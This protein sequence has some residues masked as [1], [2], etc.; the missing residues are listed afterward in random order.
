MI[1][2]VI[3]YSKYFR[4]IAFAIILLYPGYVSATDYTW[5]G[6]TSAWTTSTNWSP[7]SPAGG[8]T[9]SD[10]V[11]IA[12]VVSPKVAPV[13]SSSV[14]VGGLIMNSGRLTINKNIILTVTT[15]LTVT[16]AATK[17]LGSGSL[18]VGSSSTYAA[19]V[20]FG[21]ESAGTTVDPTLI[22]YSNVVAMTKVVFKTVSLTATDL[23]INGCTFGGT[24]TLTKSGDPSGVINGTVQ[25]STI[26]SITNQGN[27]PL[28][29][30]NADG[31]NLVFN[32]ATTFINTGSGSILFGNT[33]NDVFSFRS[34]AVFTK[35]STGPIEVARFGNTDFY[36]T[37][38]VNLPSGETSTLGNVGGGW[39]NF[40]GTVSQVIKGTASGL[41]IN[42]ISV[43]KTAGTLTIQVPLN[44]VSIVGATRPNP[45]LSLLNGI[46]VTTTAKLITIPDA[47]SITLNQDPNKSFISGPVKKVGNAA[48]TFP[49]GKGAVYRPVSIAAPAPEGSCTFVAEYFNAVP[50]SSTSLNADV[51]SVSSCEYWKLTKE[52]G[53]S[54]VKVT[55]G[56]SSSNC[57]TVQPIGIKLCRF[58]ASNKWESVSANTETSTITSSEVLET[59]GN[60]ALGYSSK[61]IYID[62]RLLEPVNFS[63]SGA[64]LPDGIVYT[65]AKSG[66]AKDGLI[67]ILPVPL[68][69]GVTPI[70]IDIAEGSE[71]TSMKITFDID[72]LYTISNVKASTDNS[73]LLRLM[74]A[75][76]YTIN[77][78]PANGKTIKFLRGDEKASAS[79]TTNLVDGTTMMN[80]TGSNFQVLGLTGYIIKSF[81]IL[82]L[83]N[84]LV[85]G[86]LTTAVWDGTNVD[87]QEVTN[88]VYKFELVITN[89]SNNYTYTGQIIVK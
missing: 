20:T 77:N 84:T 55:L 17:V 53:T 66:P 42:K 33:D 14:T 34:T 64:Q 22:V 44:L 15:N 89:S 29:L 80:S 73:G 2:D 27:G 57:E 45:E 11:I 81:K 61:R 26:A 23:T 76:F 78:A 19:Q 72:N 1:F 70:T 49:I 65:S 30:G 82:S 63:I 51:S 40:K 87:S 9:A 13:V 10:N 86:P 88:G 52:A 32:G 75:D 36:N 43:D 85:K 59:Y 4:V 60:L 54:N 47:T 12:S 3:I 69:S 35:S 25:F 79:F 31:D 7:V 37:I 38:T 21:N 83:D 5:V 24:F 46:V 68:S 58:N 18:A 71:N 56:W 16:G 50:T 74:T 39:C 8:P 48:F 67:P 41:N 28:L 62:T 6:T